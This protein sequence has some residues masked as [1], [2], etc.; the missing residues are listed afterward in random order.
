MKRKTCVIVDVA[1]V[2][3]AGTV[4]FALGCVKRDS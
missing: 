3:L 4:T 2:V 1:H